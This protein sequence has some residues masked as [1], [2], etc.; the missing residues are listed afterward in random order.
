MVV[1]R[2][3]SAVSALASV[4]LL[5]ACA[6]TPPPRQT[7]WRPSGAPIAPTYAAPLPRPGGLSLTELPGWT[8]EDHAAALLA[9]EQT[10]NLVRHPD[11]AEVCQ[12]ARGL[13]AVGEFR[14]REFLEANFRAQ[15][16]PGRGL[17][18]A[19]F[20]PEYEARASRRGEFTAAVR[21]RPSDLLTL[22]LGAFDPTL[23]GRK[24]S[25]RLAD[26]QL[27]PYPDRAAIEAQEPGEALAWMRPEDLFFL[28]IQGSGVLQL[29]DGR[30]FK[31][32]FSASNGRPFVG[33]ANVLR[34]RGDLAA[35]NTSGDSIRAWLADHRGPEADDVMRKNPRYVF[36]KL[37]PDD[38]VEPAGAA[39][40]PLIPG[41]ALA[42][43]PSRHT[44]GG[45]YW[46][47]ASTPNLSGAFPDYRRLAIALDVG[48]A[49]KG[50]VRA[51]LYMGRGEAAGVEAGRVRH[52]LTLYAL[53]PITRDPG[54]P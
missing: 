10:C 29:P 32:S 11:L 37:V 28:Q 30:R 17:L 45:L 51:D 25:G 42:M 3:G 21:A 41:R 18:T 47:D 48:A 24:I 2:F 34:D 33:I 26:G 19:Y 7:A 50:D 46:I 12:R 6:T 53:E 13:G 40:A 52:A 44:M 23:A 4:L 5:A 31:A 38:G 16:T 43:D 27:L 8:Q 9:F 54:S 49:I 1:L 35:D 39:G 15:P 14:A 22:D 36:F 20:A